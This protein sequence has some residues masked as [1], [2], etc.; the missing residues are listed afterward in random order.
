L[1]QKKQKDTATVV[2]SDP[3]ADRCIIRAET[4]QLR[5][6]IGVRT[7]RDLAVGEKV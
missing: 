1:I 3:R 5:P 7:H 2:A 4:M 6:I